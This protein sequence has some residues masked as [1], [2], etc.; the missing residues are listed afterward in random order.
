MNCTLRTYPSVSF[1][2]NTH[3]NR[4]NITLFWLF[5]LLLLPTMLKAQDLKTHINENKITAA[6]TELE[7]KTVEKMQQT[8]LPGLAIG[9]V[10]QDRVLYHKGFGVREAGKPGKGRRRHRISTGLHFQTVRID[11]DCRI[12]QRWSHGL[13]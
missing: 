6:I 9:I 11:R 3:K 5:V 2:I 8:G 7:K 4:T 1:G 13:E 12:S 10:Y